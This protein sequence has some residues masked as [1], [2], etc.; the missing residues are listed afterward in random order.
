MTQDW[1]AKDFGPGSLALLS[2]S[3]KGNKVTGRE[4][5]RGSIPAALLMLPESSPPDQLRQRR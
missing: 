1:T 3:S 4:R 2:Q 5:E